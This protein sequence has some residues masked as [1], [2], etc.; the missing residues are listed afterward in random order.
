M[1]TQQPKSQVSLSNETQPTANPEQTEQSKEDK[2]INEALQ[3][4]IQNRVSSPT[5]KTS[6]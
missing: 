3:A 1:T 5:I 6:E 2:E 4:I